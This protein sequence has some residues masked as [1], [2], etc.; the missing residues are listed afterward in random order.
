MKFLSLIAALV[1]M[2][3]CAFAWPDTPPAQLF[4]IALL[5]MILG[6]QASTAMRKDK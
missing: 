2:A 4:A 3:A 5:M 6:N 1:A